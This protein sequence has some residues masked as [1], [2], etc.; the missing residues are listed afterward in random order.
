MAAGAVELDE[1]LPSRVPSVFFTVCIDGS[2]QLAETGPRDR[3]DPAVLARHR[4]RERT[5][6][7][8]TR[9]TV[10][11]LG[12][13]QD[14]VNLAIAYPPDPVHDALTVRGTASLTVTGPDLALAEEHLRREQQGDLDR[15]DEHRRLVFRQRILADPDLRPV[16][17]IDRYPERINDLNQ[18][19]TAVQGLKPPRSLEHHALRDEIVRFIDQLLMDIRTPHQREIFLRA[20]TQTLQALG[21]TEL[22]QTAAAWLPTT[23]TDSGDDPA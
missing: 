21:S 22:H 6:R 9:H 16:W 3:R 11:E 10:L 2:W 13:A 19:N 7:A 12:A 15:G 4:L 17:W 1:R 14:A 20:L 23:R 5:R 8:L 18:L